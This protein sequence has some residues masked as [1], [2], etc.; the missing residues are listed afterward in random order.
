MDIRKKLLMDQK[1]LINE[2]PICIVAFGDSVTHGSFLDEID[3]DAAYWNLLRKKINNIRSFVPVN[4]INAGI[5]GIS[6]KDSLPRL[7]KQVLAHNPDLVIVCFGLN[8]MGYPL[9]EYLS[10]LGTIFDRCTESGAEVIYMSPNMFNTYVA[11]DTL[12]KHREYAVC[13]A[14]FQ[15]SGRADLYHYA[16]MNLARE[17]NVKVCDCY[18]KWKKLSE[19]QDTTMLLVNRVNHPTKEMHKLFADSLFETIFDEL[20]EKMENSSTMFDNN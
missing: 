11:D 3:Y 20:P 13:T 19:T 5:G 15:N 17:K 12:P 2:G 1:Q 18:S 16:A 14:D 9:E 8:D 4:V 7:D 6:A 10:A